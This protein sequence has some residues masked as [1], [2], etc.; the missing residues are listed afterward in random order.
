MKT[1]YGFLCIISLILYFYTIDL[2]STYAA[3]FFVTNTA[4]TGEGSLREVLQIS[5]SNGEFDVISFQIPKSDP[6]YNAD[7]G[8]WTFIPHSRYTI[9]TDPGLMIEG[10]SQRDFIGEDTNPYG[11]EIEIVGSF[12]S[13]VLNGLD[14]RTSEVQI[15][16]LTLNQF[17]N[18]GIHLENA[19]HCTIAGCYIGTNH[20][21]EEPLGNTYGIILKHS[22]HN[23]IVALDTVPNIISGNPWVGIYLMDSSQFNIVADNI[24]GMNRTR[25]DTLGNGLKGNYGGIVIN[26]SSNNNEI[27]NNDITGNAFG[28]YLWDASSNV[29]ASNRIGT[30]QEWKTG[31]GSRDT[32]ILILSYSVE[33]RNN[34]IMENTIGYSGWYGI[35][36]DGTMCKYNTIIR[37]SVAENNSGAI[38][39][40]GGANE[41]MNQPVIQTVTPEMVTGTADPDAVIEIFRDDDNECRD[42]L[43]STASSA[44]GNFTFSLEGLSL[45]GYIT[46]TATDGPGNTSG[47]SNAVAIPASFVGNTRLAFHFQLKQN[48]PNPFNPKTVIPFYLSEGDQ[49]ILTVFNLL[50]EKIEI[51]LDKW[52]PAGEHR[53]VWQPENLPAGIYLYRLTSGRFEAVKKFI[54][55]K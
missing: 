5:A 50:G 19:D 14:V 51:I 12:D 17:S 32:G 9:L 36:I 55:E 24:I 27:V 47:L 15:R 11:P 49:T 6:G 28:I 7:T 31:F 42:Y 43:G 52:L 20:S 2:T 30:D 1:R 26:N 34:T 41:D 23:Q 48:Y 3:E 4:D 13:S 16:H 40:T 38:V 35:Y 18:T 45:S 46:A 37:N 8:V 25:D 33:S 21:G 29:L 54:Y 53:A 39:I 44:A 22:S 10:L